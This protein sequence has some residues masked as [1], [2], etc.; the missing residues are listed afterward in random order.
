MARRGRSGICTVVEVSVD[1]AA[2][3]TAVGVADDEGRGT[4]VGA[5]SELRCQG[6][7][8][9]SQEQHLGLHH[10]ECCADGWELAG[11]GMAPNG[12]QQG[13]KTLVSLLSVVLDRL[14][15]GAL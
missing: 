9:E 4:A 12:L 11:H 13:F 7:R 1:V 2:C 5:P 3:V 14:G 8:L 6:R 15:L 10:P